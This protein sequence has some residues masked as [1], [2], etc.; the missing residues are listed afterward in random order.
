M[1]DRPTLRQILLLP[2][3]PF[4]FIL[5]HWSKHIVSTPLIIIAVLFISLL[6]GSDYLARAAIAVVSFLA[7]GVLASEFED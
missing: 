5:L 7:G 4:A 1:R 6:P 3:A 2:L